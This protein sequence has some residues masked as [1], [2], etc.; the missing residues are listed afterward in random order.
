MRGRRMGRRAV[1][2]PDPLV[3]GPAPGASADLLEQERGV[4]VRRHRHLVVQAVPQAAI[5][6]QGGGG[7]AAGIQRGYEPARG[8]V[9]QRIEQFRPLEIGDRLRVVPPLLRR[10][11]QLLQRLQALGSAAPALRMDPLLVAT[12]QQ[13]TRVGP[14]GG[15]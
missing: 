12:L 1:W 3:P 11:R 15:P 2:A 13:R 14:D 7:I 8:R 9:P 10:F 5:D 6:L 4:R